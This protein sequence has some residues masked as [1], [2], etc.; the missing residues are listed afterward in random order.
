M[1]FNLNNYPFHIAFHLEEKCVEP[2]E[3]MLK[4]NKLF[5]DVLVYLFINRRNQHIL[6]DNNHYFVALF[7]KTESQ[8]LFTLMQ[9]C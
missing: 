3:E 5:W 1:T 8:N 2:A 9:E 7:C 6:K 4:F